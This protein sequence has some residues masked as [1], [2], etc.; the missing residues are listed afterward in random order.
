MRSFTQKLEL[1]SDIL[2]LIVAYGNTLTISIFILVSFF[3][4]DFSRDL[5]NKKP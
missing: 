5:K 3:F 2:Q 1:V 4:E